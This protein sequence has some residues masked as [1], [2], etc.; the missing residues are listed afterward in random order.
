MVKILETTNTLQ[1]LPILPTGTMSG[2]IRE[3]LR[4][5]AENIREGGFQ[6]NGIFA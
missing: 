4:I 3:A 2:G 5:S 1:N 6:E